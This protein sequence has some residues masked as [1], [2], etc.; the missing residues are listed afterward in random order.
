MH[1]DLSN[2]FNSLPP[3]VTKHVLQT[4]VG[5]ECSL[6]L[7][8]ADAQMICGWSKTPPWAAGE[9][10]TVLAEYIPWRDALLKEWCRRT[11]NRLVIVTC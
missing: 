9:R 5:I 8:E 11:G 10:Q 3:L 6:S 4:S 7:R 2:S 1:L